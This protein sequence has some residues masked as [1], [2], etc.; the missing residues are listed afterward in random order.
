MKKLS[1]LLFLLFH[2]ITYSQKTTSY[3]NIG[4]IFPKDY[5]S[6]LFDNSE[7]FT[8]TSNEIK[9]LE[10]LLN[11]NIKAINTNKFT[12]LIHKN[13]DKY[14]RQ[15]IGF[16]NEK[17]ERIIYINFLW[18]ENYTSEKNGKPNGMMSQMEA[19]IIGI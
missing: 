10:F 5:D 19:V 11:K 13:L 8:P 2:L 7:R 15:Y 16:F 4:V 17:G 6:Y 14:N 18:R 12:P 3:K 1:I 9:E